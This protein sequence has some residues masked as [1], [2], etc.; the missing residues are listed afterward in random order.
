MKTKL[1]CILALLNCAILGNAAEPAKAAERTCCAPAKM[2]ASTPEGS[3]NNEEQDA[4]PI[5]ARSIYQLTA[6]FTDDAGQPTA[7]ASFR[8]QPVV[9]AMF[10]ASC[11]YACP[12]IVADMQR[13]R[14]ELPSAVREHTQF[15]LVSFDV[16]RDT[17]PVLKTYRE[18]MKLDQAWTLLH[19]NAADVQELAM[20]VGVKFKQDVR[21]QF[22]HSN[23]I[24][25][26]NPEGE[27]VHQRAGLGG[28]VEEAAKAVTL[29]P[30]SP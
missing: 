21:G 25:V 29:S 2:A 19:G 10:F 23:L 6:R 26:L 8:G 3:G 12:L 27:I 20:L 28:S 22:S 9:L 18:R 30:K 24:T 14:A 7:L 5:A 15:V 13:L 4:R 16:A 17:P 11:E 1:A